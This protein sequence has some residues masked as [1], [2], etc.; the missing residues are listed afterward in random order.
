MVCCISSCARGALVQR[1]HICDY[2]AC[3]IDCVGADGPGQPCAWLHGSVNALR[4]TLAGTLAVVDLTTR[5]LFFM[6]WC[7]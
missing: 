1:T 4:V 3:M 5:S 6:A 7:A 2:D